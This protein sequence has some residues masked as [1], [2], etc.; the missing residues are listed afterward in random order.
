MW[1][2]LSTLAFVLGAQSANWGIPSADGIPYGLADF[3][4]LFFVFFV[5]PPHFRW[6]F[7]VKE[8]TDWAEI[9]HNHT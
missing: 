7:V 4:F 1:N 9:L 5:L 6:P 3:F 8:T 2:G